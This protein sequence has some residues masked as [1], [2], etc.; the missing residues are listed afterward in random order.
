MMR[1]MARGNWLA[2]TD[3]PLVMGILNVT[4]D[5]FSDGGRL[6]SVEGAAV[7]AERMVAAGADLIDVGGESTRPGS[8]SISVVEELRRVIPVVERLVGQVSVPLSVDTTKPTVAR[9]AIEAG[10]AII[11]DVQGLADPAMMAVV[12]EASVGVVLMHIQGTPRTM[13]DAPKYRDVVREVADHLA[14]RVFQAG[15]AGI[16][17]DRIAIDPGIGFGKSFTHNLELLRNLEQFHAIGCPVLIGTSR[18][19]FLGTITGRTVGDRLAASVVSS[20]AAAARGASIVR[21]HD[22]AET[23]DGLLVWGAQ[24]GWKQF[25]PLAPDDPGLG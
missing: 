15:L 16:T 20:L 7:H 21:V 14:N 5:S 24:N 4:P 11:N 25:G 18:K 1:W 3:R 8:E 13:Q 22:V 23:V 9:V 17:R 2:R 12:A 10:A 19:G 6:T